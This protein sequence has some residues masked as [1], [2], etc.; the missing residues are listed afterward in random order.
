MT[1]CRALLWFLH[2]SYPYLS[3]YSPRPGVNIDVNKIDIYGLLR[4]TLV[5]T[6]LLSLPPPPP[7]RIHAPVIWVSIGS[8]NGFSPIRR[9]AIIW[10]N[11]WLL[12]IGPLGTNFSD[13]LTKNT[14]M[15]QKMS[16][17]KWRPFCLW[18]DELN[19]KISLSWMYKQ[20]VTPLHTLFSINWL[21]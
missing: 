6:H 17:S 7:C 11:V 8:D 19:T 21:Q 5:L 13:I 10:T 1:T 18:G 15:Y 20:F 2:W 14:K 3:R 12:S 16:S 4:V 9:Q